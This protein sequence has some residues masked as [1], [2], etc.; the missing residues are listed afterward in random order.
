MDSGNRQ[1]QTECTIYK[2][3]HVG[4]THARGG[5]GGLDLGQN[6]KYP[7]QTRCL[8][9]QAFFVKVPYPDFWSCP[10]LVGVGGLVLPRKP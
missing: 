4:V 10:R 8:L 9:P 2:V 1:G 6:P 3:P 5:F 7:S